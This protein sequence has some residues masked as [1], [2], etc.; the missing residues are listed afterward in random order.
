MIDILLLLN[1]FKYIKY[2]MN[3]GNSTFPK[4]I[5]YT[6]EQ[7]QKKINGLNIIVRLNNILK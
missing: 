5:H 3:P 2:K 1:H 7:K 4:Q 6:V